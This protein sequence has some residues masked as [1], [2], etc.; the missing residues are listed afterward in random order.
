[1]EGES[2]L[3]I[4]RLER[5]MSHISKFRFSARKEVQKQIDS[6]KRRQSKVELTRDQKKL[7]KELTEYSSLLPTMP[8]ISVPMN[9]FH[10]DFEKFAL[11][12]DTT[13][14]DMMTDTLILQIISKHTK[15]SFPSDS[16]VLQ[17][18]LKTLWNDRST[19]DVQ[20][21]TAN[22]I[23][24]AHQ[25]IL[26]ARCPYFQSLLE[27]K[28][29]VDSIPTTNEDKT[30]PSFETK[31]SKEVFSALLEYLYTG[32]IKQ[33]ELVNP[34]DIIDLMVAADE[35]GLPH[36]KSVCEQNLQPHL[37][38][39][40]V[41][42]CCLGAQFYGFEQL[43]KSCIFIMSQTTVYPIVSQQERFKKMDSTTLENVQKEYQHLVGREKERAQLQNKIEECKQKIAA[44]HV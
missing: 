33:N 1:L 15:Y 28:D 38:A 14:S 21:T 3:L 43:L 31:L 23:F 29:N 2:P 13:N 16:I 32:E 5:K 34:N 44:L 20:F 30:L 26:K 40:T 4:N 8:T 17:E 6:I 11:H 7:E 18:G 39:D 19:A 37:N 35:Y 10:N 22:T 25:V 24:Y 9:P 42:E 12:N 27:W 36:L 41:V